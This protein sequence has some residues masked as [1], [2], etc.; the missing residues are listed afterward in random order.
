MIN[1]ISDLSTYRRLYKTVEQ[2]VTNNFG[3]S[4]ENMQEFR[5][6]LTL[7]EA[8]LQWMNKRKGEIP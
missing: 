1:G 3:I 5:Q 7:I 2:F 6:P 4:F 8:L